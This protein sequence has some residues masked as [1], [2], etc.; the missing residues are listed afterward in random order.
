M[1]C[2]IIKT[3]MRKDIY[4]KN[5]S[6][7]GRKCLLKMW[8]IH[9]A[10]P[11]YGADSWRQTRTATRR[12]SLQKIG[13]R[14]RY[15]ALCQRLPDP[16]VHHGGRSADSSSHRSEGP[17]ITVTGDT[18]GWE[19]AGASPPPVPPNKGASKRRST[20]QNAA[21]HPLVLGRQTCAESGTHASVC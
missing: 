4:K 6:E 1:F 19:G 16:L 14:A 9:T 13:R 21:E 15:S 7:T 20:L 2:S 5:S 3:P 12:V 17:F 18:C 11:A 10:S 8:I